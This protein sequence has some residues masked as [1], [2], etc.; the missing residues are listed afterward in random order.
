MIPWDW[1]A[2][3]VDAQAGNRILPDHAQHLTMHT[4]MVIAALQ[5]A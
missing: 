3:P 1:N 4:Q 2:G 5:T